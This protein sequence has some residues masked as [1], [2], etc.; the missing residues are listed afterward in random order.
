VP[1]QIEQLRGEFRRID[2]GGAA[3]ANLR[4]RVRI[5]A[6]DLDAPA[7]RVQVFTPRA[8]AAAEP[9][10]P[11]AVTAERGAQPEPA[12][13]AGHDPDRTFRRRPEPA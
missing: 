7:M 8:T 3:P 2:H 13:G 12:A 6:I 5:D 4:G 11:P 1:E 10:M 9:A